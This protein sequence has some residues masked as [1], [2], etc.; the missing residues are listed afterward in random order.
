[1]TTEKLIKKMIDWTMGFW[2]LFQQEYLEQV[3]WNCPSSIFI[4]TAYPLRTLCKLEV[5]LFILSSA[6]YLFIMYSFVVIE[7]NIAVSGT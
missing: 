6:V 4:A 7:W 2:K 3:A 5:S 1:M